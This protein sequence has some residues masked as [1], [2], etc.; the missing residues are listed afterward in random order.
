MR[1]K[2]E[3]AANVV[4]PQANMSL[5]SNLLIGQS[6]L[7]AANAGI[8]ATS[9]NVANSGSPGFTRRRLVNGVA[10]P[11]RHGR[12]WLGQGATTQGME[13][14]TDH[15]MTTRR[16]QQAGVQSQKGFAWRTMRSID[17]VM[18]AG[19]GSTSKDALDSFFDSLTRATADPSDQSLRRGIVR[20][21]QF[22]VSLV[23]RDGRAFQNAIDDHES[24]AAN[25]LPVINEKLAKVAL[26]NRAI[27][28]SVSQ[29]LTAGDFSDQRDLLLRD[30][31]ELAG[32]NVHLESNG[33][34]TVFMG[35]HVAVTGEESRTLSSDV[36]SGDLRILMSTSR[37]E[38]VNITSGMGGEIGGHLEV[39]E[40]STDY[41]GRL[42][43]FA[44][45]MATAMN[46]QHRAG[47]DYLGAAGGDLF[48]FDASNAAQTL[49]MSA[50]VLSNPEHIAFGGTTPT[51][52]GDIDNLRLLIGMENNL[53]VDGARTANQWLTDIVTEVGTDIANLEQ[54]AITHEAVL[55]DMDEM[56]QNLHG[57]DLDEEATQLVMYQAAYQASARVISTSQDML[58]ILME[59]VR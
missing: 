51:L 6:G 44:E 31:G 18:D 56:D 7:R 28:S 37:D 57:V 14:V 55:R 50:N 13:R 53:I 26:L 40:L 54:L 2:I 21:G 35:G 24:D 10:N 4:P 48:S 38:F 25:S 39:R 34:A 58:G 29:G 3:P 22:L 49:T 33:V 41:L 8:S 45:D 16:I 47:Y 20:S 12:V 32:I 15:L 1:L 23:A 19:E 27:K 52:S 59:L 43:T 17:R 11:L 5:L 30:L 36:S 42:N 9:H 46:T